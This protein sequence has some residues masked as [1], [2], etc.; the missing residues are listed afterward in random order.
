MTEQTSDLLASIR[1]ALIDV[2][3]PLC[4]YLVIDGAQ[5]PGLEDALHDIGARSECLF[6]GAL[7][8]EVA[9]VAPY[10]IAIEGN[11]AV[12]TSLLDRF[13]P[14]PAMIFVRT[15]LSFHELRRHL[16]KLAMAELPDRQVVFF[17]YYDPRVLMQ[18]APILTEDQRLRLFGATDEVEV[19]VVDDDGALTDV[20]AVARRSV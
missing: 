11:D 17:R 8:P 20:A 6:S 5:A 16:R 9:A 4:G 14:H 7:E 1:H 19:L 10:L 13:G 12:L 15:I 3:A 2:D 18:I